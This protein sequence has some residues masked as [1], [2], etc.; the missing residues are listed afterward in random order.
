[1]CR[2][3]YR[4]QPGIIMTMFPW[5]VLA[6]VAASVIAGSAF[7]QVFYEPFN[8]GVG[9]TPGCHT[10]EFPGGSGTFP[11]PAAW[12]LFNV[13]QLVPDPQVAYVNDAWEVREDF[14]GDASQCVA[15]S[16]SYYN[17]A[18]QA[19]DWMWTPAI[20]VPDGGTLSWRAKAYD[21]K[22]RDGYE[23]RILSDVPPTVDN[24]MTSTVVYANPGEESAWTERTVDIS[25]YAGQTVYIA[26]RNNSNDKFLLVVDDVT[27]RAQA[28]NLAATA[29]TTFSS[30]YSLA[31]E[32]FEIVPTLAVTAV[33]NGTDALT[34]VAATATYKLDGVATGIVMQSAVLPSLG[35]AESA[36]M[37][38]EPAPAFSGAGVWSVE[39]FVS[40][41]QTPDEPDQA[42]NVLASEGTTIG[43][44]E[45][46]RFE[47][48]AD[49][50]LGIGAGTGGELGVA[51]TLPMDTQVTGVHFAMGALPPKSGD[52]PAPTP[53]PGF[54]YVVNLRGFDMGNGVP[55]DL[56]DTT[57]PVPCTYAGGSYDVEFAG[58]PHLLAAGT[59]V[60]TA[61]EPVGGQ[62]LPLPLHAQRFATGTTWVYWPETPFG[63]WAHLEDFGPAF[64]KTPEL[65]LLT[66]EPPIFADGFDGT[67][68][69]VRA[70]RRDAAPTIMKDRRSAAPTR[71]VVPV[72]VR[73]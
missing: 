27:V 13:D 1:M 4:P 34:N 25:A 15:F 20:V 67:A 14:S 66:G 59:Y 44:D 49:G 70:I 52:P 58:G 55:G 29:A 5:K 19:D 45:F 3:H 33:N 11:F 18:G 12:T 38:F 36:P 35:A 31:P 16:T 17:P 42:D 8:I 65:S 24:Q 40:A 68:A 72:I 46:A 51:L 48:L 30:E 28:T 73:D 64:A 7:A 9:E 26:F 6:F 61:V 56:I 53:C 21:P 39:Y 50:V 37:S 71:L 23:V 10:E 69:P 60:L 63:G 32:G 43:G 41:D 54:D 22:F 47:G 57:V 62:T 2:H